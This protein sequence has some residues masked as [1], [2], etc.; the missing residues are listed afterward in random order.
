MH[1]GFWLLN[2][3]SVCFCLFL[4]VSDPFCV[5]THRAVSFSGI[6]CFGFKSFFF[7][8]QC[9]Y[10]CVLCSLRE[11]ARLELPGHLDRVCGS[12]LPGSR[13]R[14]FSGPSDLRPGAKAEK[15]AVLCLPGSVGLRLGP[16][17]RTC[18]PPPGSDSR[19]HLASS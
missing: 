1:G 13:Q 19:D 2:L 18:R 6:Q 4:R 9:F 15:P 11:R 16:G 3:R 8:F 17:R 12:G 10:D 7:M 14:D 5:F